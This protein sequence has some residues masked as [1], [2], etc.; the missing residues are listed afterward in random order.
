LGQ[1]GAKRLV[2]AQP[3][4]QRFS[5]VVGV[6]VLDDEDGCRQVRRQFTDELIEGLESASGCAHDNDVSSLRSHAVY[7]L[8]RFHLT[9]RRITF[10][11]DLTL[12]GGALPQHMSP[13]SEVQFIDELKRVREGTAG[14]VHPARFVC[15]AS[16]YE[17]VD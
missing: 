4:Q 9:L 5:R 15:N 16:Y 17:T 14:R 8:S 7:C 1:L 10:P 6:H 11:A 3:T 2:S 12:T 13:S